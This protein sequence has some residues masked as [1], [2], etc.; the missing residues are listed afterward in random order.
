LVDENLNPIILEVRCSLTPADA[1]GG[2]SLFSPF[3]ALFR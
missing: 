1:C 2:H 3:R